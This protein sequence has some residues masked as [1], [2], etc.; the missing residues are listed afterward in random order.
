[1]TGHTPDTAFALPEKWTSRTGTGTGVGVGVGVGVGTG[2]GVGVGVGVGVGDGVVAAAC[3]TF[4]GVPATTAD[5]GR[6]APEF[7]VTITRTSASPRPDAGVTDAHATALFAVHAQAE[8][9]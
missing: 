7:V 3:I 8:W 6:A 9:V 2:D 5:T 1:M 4:T